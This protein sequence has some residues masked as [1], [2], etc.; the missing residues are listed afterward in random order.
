[1]PLCVHSTTEYFLTVLARF[2]PA[3][4]IM[5]LSGII[6]AK[7]G[8]VVTGGG[9]VTFVLGC[10]EHLD[11]EQRYVAALRLHEAVKELSVHRL[12]GIMCEELK[13]VFRKVALLIC[14]YAWMLHRPT[15]LLCF[16]AC[17]CMRVVNAT[18]FNLIVLFVERLR[19]KLKINTIGSSLVSLLLSRMSEAAVIEAEMQGDVQ[20]RKDEDDRARSRIGFRL[21]GENE[22]QADLIEV[23]EVMEEVNNGE[24]LFIHLSIKNRIVCLF[25]CLFCTHR[26]TSLTANW[27]NP[28]IQQS[29]RY[30]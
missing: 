28:H 15:A 5:L 6:T 30:C 29:L 12:G 19:A 17:C 26:T 24:T 23:Y 10:R 9:L 4:L 11:H 18:E 21:R 14:L 25:V 20:L 7:H 1:M 3:V 16:D 8:N 27:I 2:E 13:E 22:L